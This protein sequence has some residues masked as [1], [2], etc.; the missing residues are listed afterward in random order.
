[1]VGWA[2]TLTG[3]Q[4]AF[5]AIGGG[6]IETLAFP[7]GT[8]SYAFGINGAGVIVGASYINGEAHGAVWTESGVTD[9]G[10][11]VYAMGIND[12][13]VIIG[14]NGHAFKLVDGVYR[15]L[16][17]LAGGD[18]S[19]AYA[20]ND[21]GAAV[22]YGNLASGSFRGIVWDPAG[23]MIELGTLGGANSYAMGI[24]E[25]GEVVGHSGVASGYEHA[26]LAIAGVLTDLGTLGGG[27]SYAYGINDG[28]GIVGYSWSD[29]EDTPRAFLYLGG[30]MRDL[31]ALIPGGCGWQLL[32]AY[33]IN[34]A[35]QIVG[36]GLYDGQPS[37]FRLDPVNRSPLAA[38][39]PVP[40][41]DSLASAAVALM[42]LALVARPWR[43]RN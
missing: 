15:D 12:G 39:E 40:E 29:N 6:A 36:A 7:S 24:N 3:V 5:R 10:A 16:G 27:S 31:N 17:A 35:G 25:S 42:I 2:E 19:A 32:S 9:L 4:Q 43:G 23:A 30:V 20:V 28:G 37:A 21:S 14:S 41:P 13:G 11:G 18:W 26:F 22:G 38:P 34:E 1:V 33:G 8:D